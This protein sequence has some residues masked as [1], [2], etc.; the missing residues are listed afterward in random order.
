MDNPGRRKFVLAATATAAGAAGLAA[1]VWWWHGRQA[2]HAHDAHDAHPV[3]DPAFPR[4]LRVPG[5]DGL[6][7]VVDLTGTLTMTARALTRAETLGDFTPAL[8]YE[9]EFDGRT[10][11]NPVLKVRRDTPV[12]VKF[13]NALDDE[14]IIHWHGLIVDSNNDGHPHYAVPGGATYDYHFTVVNRAATYWY[15]PHPHHLSGKQ[16]ALGLAGLLIVEDEDELRLQQA[17]DLKFGATD[18][19][20]VIQDRSIDA[21]GRPLY[22]AGAEERL[23]GHLGGE[24]LVNFTRRPYFNAATR[25]YRFRILNGSNARLYR[26]AFAQ[27]DKL[28]PYRIIGTDGGLLDAARDVTEAFLSPSERVD[29]LLDLRAVPAGGTVLLK[30]LPFDPM[31]HE[32]AG[33][34]PAADAASAVQAG[35][36]GHHAT[37]AVAQAPGPLPD[38]AAID[39][40][41]IRVMHRVKY[42]RSVPAALS[43]IAPLAT[44]AAKTRVL[45]LE[46]EEKTFKINKLRYSIDETPIVVRRGSV[47][48]WEYRNAA[49]NMPHPMHV[50]GFQFQVLERINSPAQQKRLAVNA[51]GLAATD[52]GWKDTVLTW[53]GE[54][55]RIALDFTHPFLGDQV[56]MLH[57]HNLEHEDGGMMLNFKVAG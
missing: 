21:D 53:P 3:A 38:G 55:V 10:F 2:P 25:I 29:V 22:I 54:T 35:H 27:G 49:R 30:S 20:L 50:H 14:S 41:Q 1:G 42:D 4:P 16:T 43:T 13:W 34:A 23:H 52:L 6:L 17:L 51:A 57:C 47:E 39:L 45:Y 37:E 7:G 12:R 11:F 46:F 15:H 5:S 33:E 18:V 24:V 56:Y 36:H 31:H 8:A 28:L 26:L 19:P 48:I 32:A 44:A 9:A 40:M